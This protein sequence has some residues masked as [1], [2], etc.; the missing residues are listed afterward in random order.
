[1]EIRSFRWDEDTIDHIANHGVRPD[2]VEEVAFNE[3]DVIF[4]AR[5]WV[6]GTFL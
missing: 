1:M 3:G 2:E 4:M 6:D 5:R